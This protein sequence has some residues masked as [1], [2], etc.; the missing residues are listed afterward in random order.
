MLHFKL[1]GITKY[2]NTVSIVL[3]ADPDLTLGSKDQNSTLSEHGH[4]AYQIKFNH[5]I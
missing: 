5:E 3:P 1:N 2:S 4:V